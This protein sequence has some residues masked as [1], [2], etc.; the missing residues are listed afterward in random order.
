LVRAHPR[1]K[2]DCHAIE[3]ELRAQ[4]GARVYVHNA[5]DWPLY[6]VLRSV[7]IHVT[8]NSTCANE[9]LAFGTP[10]ILINEEGATTFRT[11][12]DAGV[13][14][15]ARTPDDFCDTVER[16][17]KVDSTNLKRAGQEIFSADE[18]DLEAAIDSITDIV[19][20][21]SGEL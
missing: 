1:E 14:F 18:K 2:V 15:H 9:A 17:L 6:A 16:A 10:T 3:Q 12:I 20:S 8:I 5:N 21:G 7:D 11:F 13:M 4:N 19:R